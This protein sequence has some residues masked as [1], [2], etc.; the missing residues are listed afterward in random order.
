MD[1]GEDEVDKEELILP[2]PA[3]QSTS[4]QCPPHVFP[5]DSHIESSAG[6]P[7]YT[8][9]FPTVTTFSNHCRIFPIIGSTYPSSSL[10]LHLAYPRVHGGCQYPP[11]THR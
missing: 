7:V 9:Y 11:E 8:S 5:T 6:S 10:P 3:S 1:H 2:H 4:P